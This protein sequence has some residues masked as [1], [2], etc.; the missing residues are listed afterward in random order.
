MKKGG[1]KAVL[2]T[3]QGGKLTAA[4]IGG[5]VMLTDEKGGKATVTV[6]DLAVTNGV[7]HLIDAVLML[8]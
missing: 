5:K 1:G 2:T 3:V 8:K 6:T 7:V 4:I